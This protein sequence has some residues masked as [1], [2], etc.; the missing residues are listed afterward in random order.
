MLVLHRSCHRPVGTDGAR[1]SF[2]GFLCPNLGTG[3]H[4]F[5]G[6]F[7]HITVEGMEK[8]ED[9]ILLRRMVFICD[10][11]LLYNGNV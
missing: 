11:D 4:T 6:V 9:R 2:K 5:H 3:G 10:T 8:S 7:E 1:L